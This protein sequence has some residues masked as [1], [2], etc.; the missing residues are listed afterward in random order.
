MEVNSDVSFVIKPVLFVVNQISKTPL[1]TGVPDLVQLKSE[2]DG[3]TG[4]T[5]VD[6]ELVFEH[7]THSETMKDANRIFFMILV[8]AELQQRKI[9]Y[10]NCILYQSANVINLIK[11]AVNSKGLIFS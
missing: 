4:G 9:Q 3:V 1:D 10:L 8:V 2:S 6:C 7:A 5:V 11:S